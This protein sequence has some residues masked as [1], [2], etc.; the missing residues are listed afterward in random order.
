MLSNGERLFSTIL[1]GHLV[2]PSVL[3][4]QT[5]LDHLYEL[6]TPH[7]PYLFPSTRL[8]PML[9]PI[10]HTGRPTDIIDQPVWQFLAALAL[11]ASPE[12]QQ[13]LVTA[14]REKV[15]ENVASVN[16][17]WVANEEER[18]TKLANVN[19]FL[20]A[21]GLDSSQIAM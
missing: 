8:A 19:L 1:M 5:M 6:L 2:I 11:H 12:Q 14:L 16:N 9:P 7:F 21:L 17:G 13:L 15:L 3:F 4:R 18:R 20:H 10:G